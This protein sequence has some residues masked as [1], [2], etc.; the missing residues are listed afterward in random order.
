MFPL[1]IYILF[2]SFSFYL[3]S[4]LLKLKQELIKKRKDEMKKQLRARQVNYL[5]YYFGGTLSFVIQRS[6]LMRVPL[7]WFY[8]IY[9]VHRFENLILLCKSIPFF[10]FSL[11]L[12]P[13]LSFEWWFDNFFLLCSRMIYFTISIFWFYFILLHLSRFTSI[14]CWLYCIVI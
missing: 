10:S 11:S 7:I 9:P 14:K 6:R 2:A 3:L 13:S 4:S 12:S 8:F 1:F 5:L